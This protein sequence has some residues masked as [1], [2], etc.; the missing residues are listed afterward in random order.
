MGWLAY[1]SLAA[2]LLHPW[3]RPRGSIWRGV[4][5]GKDFNNAMNF[6]RNSIGN[7]VL[8]TWLVLG[9]VVPFV[10]M[11]PLLFA[12][13]QR[14]IGQPAFLFFPLSTALGIWFLVWTGGYRPA[15]FRRARVSEWILWI[16]IGLMAMG[17]FWYSPLVVQFAAIVVILAWSLGAFGG[18]S[19]TRI[20]AICSLFAVSV[21]LPG[22]FDARVGSWLQ[23]MSSWA[24]NGFLDAIS[25]PN[26]LEG[27]ALQV[28]VH[29][30]SVS[31]VSN[32]ADSI[33]ALMAAV[34]AILVFR[35]STLLVGVL[36][37]AAV[38]LI[39]VVGNMVRLL[40]IAIGFEYFG[41]DLTIGI[42]YIATASL[43]FV[44]D[45]ACMLLFHFAIVALVEPMRDWDA[46]N[47]L[48]QLYR[49]FASWPK[50]NAMTSELSNT[51]D[52]E[53]W[54]PSRVA[55]GICGFV[56]ALFGSLSVYASL[57]L[58]ENVGDT[59]IFSEVSA[60][61]FPSESAFRPEFGGIRKISYDTSTNRMVNTEGRFSHR[62]KFDDRGN[63]IFV[64]LD[65]PFRGW[66]SLWAGYQSAGWKIIETNELEQPTATGQAMA[67]DEFK[68]QNQ[69]GLLGFVWNGFFDENG[70]PMERSAVSNQLSRKNILS[71]LQMEPDKQVPVSFQVQVFFESGRELNEVEMERNRKL[72]FEIFEILRQQSETS[73]QKAKQARI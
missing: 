69:Y 16:G 47:S 49:R 48:T 29:K 12:Q 70:V 73:L 9:L 53:S 54:S 8:R 21:P 30:I 43:F 44:A 28:G 2:K 5:L 39:W 42:G 62:W 24:C 15:S 58:S 10:C 31:D 67:F 27:D 37:M 32:G 26:L 66:R 4:L 55:L 33:N 51:S 19:W 72:F 3:P 36:T 18:S 68:M 6:I 1:A 57:F 52:K 7:D 13:T 46:K 41:T 71:I 40:A 23:S 60:A 38:P 25:M 64:S 63:Q 11:L 20:V 65:F 34:L 22:G 59:A 45:L 50:A 35:R 56:C 61:T 17:I 14:L